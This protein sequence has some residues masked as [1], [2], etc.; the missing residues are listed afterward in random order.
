MPNYTVE[1]RFRSDDRDPES[2]CGVHLKLGYED[3]KDPYHRVRTPELTH[4]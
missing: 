4:A 2:L 3:S 1:V